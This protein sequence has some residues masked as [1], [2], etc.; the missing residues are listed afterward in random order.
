MLVLLLLLLYQ[1]STIGGNYNSY[2]SLKYLP[3]TES[4]YKCYHIPRSLTV[5]EVCQTRPNTRFIQLDDS[6]NDQLPDDL[7]ISVAKVSGQTMKYSQYMGRYS[8]EGNFWGHPSYKKVNANQWFFWNNYASTDGWY[9]SSKPPCRK[10][11]SQGTQNGVSSCLRDYGDN[12]KASVTRRGAVI[13]FNSLPTEFTSQ[14]SGDSSK[15]HVFKYSYNNLCD[16]ANTEQHSQSSGPRVFSFNAEQPITDVRVEY[17]NSG[18]CMDASCTAA[19]CHTYD[20]SVLA[21][22]DGKGVAQTVPILVDG[23]GRNGDYSDDGAHLIENWEVLPYSVSRQVRQYY[24]N[25]PPNHPY[26]TY[27]NGSPAYPHTTLIFTLVKPNQCNCE[28]GIPATGS[29]CENEGEAKCVSCHP[30]FLLSSST[31]SSF[32]TEDRDALQS[33]LVNMTTDRDRL[34]DWNRTLTV[35]LVNMATDRDRL[36]D[37]NRTLTVASDNLR[38]DKE[39]LVVERDGLVVERD[40]LVVERDELVVERDG[41]VVERDELTV[42]KSSLTAERNACEIAKTAL[43]T[44]KLALES[45]ITTLRS[46][47]SMLENNKTTLTE[48]R[49]TLMTEKLALIVERDGLLAD[50]SVLTTE[51]DTCTSEKAVVDAVI[52]ECTIDRSDLRGRLRLALLN[53]TTLQQKVEALQLTL[54]ANRKERAEN[55]KAEKDTG[56]KENEKAEKDKTDKTEKDNGGGGEKDKAE[57][58]QKQNDGA[59]SSTTLSTTTTTAPTVASSEAPTPSSIGGGEDVDLMG[60]CDE[61]LVERTGLDSS[62]MMVFGFGFFVYVITLTLALLCFVANYVVRR[63]W[64]ALR[65]TSADLQ[66][67]SVSV[68]I[69]PAVVHVQKQHSHSQARLLEKLG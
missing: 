62:S 24:N 13:R 65:G 40:E 17:S 7:V 18:G 68:K 34:Q 16:M 52:Q 50:T 31:C 8:W 2:G 44:A 51:R 69:A 19:S 61:L 47:K 49:D 32:V 58:V 41:L 28:N 23:G 42:D 54:E 15:S 39:T 56:K 35:A 33:A 46:G 37:W 60:R 48:E 6:C 29:E 45:T 5:D 30:N 43:E 10:P 63:M 12:S 1:R 20:N 4:A 3:D 26:W 55:E 27:S 64:A 11:A 67:K 14:D 57:N 38:E 36:Q 53:S 25:Y 66:E 21:F 22:V 59:K 9:L